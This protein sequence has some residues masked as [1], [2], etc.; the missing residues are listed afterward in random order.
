MTWRDGTTA[1][2]GGRMA[3]WFRALDFNVATQV[4]I[5]L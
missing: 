4:Q 1:S 3:E 2:M 5:P